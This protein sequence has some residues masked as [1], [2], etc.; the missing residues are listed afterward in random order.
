MNG[1]IEAFNK[2][3]T[4][5]LTK[6]CNTDKDNWDE[7]IPAVQWAYRIAYKRSTD[8]TPFRLVWGQ[9]AVVPLHFRQ[10]IPIITEVLHVDVKQG[11]KDRLLQLSKLEEHWLVVLQHQKIHKQQQKAWHDR[12]IK[13]KNLSVGYLALLYNSRVKRK[14]KKLHT[15][16]MGPYVVEEIHANGSVW[17]RMLQGIVFRK[18]VNGA[19]LKRYRN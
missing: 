16:W 12:N 4:K 14:P 13:N 11:R 2:T 7:K 8:Q 5:G 15:E 1:A 18:L 19:R 6:I 17:L 9:E 3:L 10:Q